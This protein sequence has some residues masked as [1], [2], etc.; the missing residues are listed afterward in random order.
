[1]S[2]KW[3][4]ARAAEARIQSEWYADGAVFRAF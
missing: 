1:M 2:A 4:P 3:A